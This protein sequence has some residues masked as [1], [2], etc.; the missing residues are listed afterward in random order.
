MNSTIIRKKKLCR[1]CGTDQYIFSK[2]RCQPC[3]TVEDTGKRVE[4]YAE[5]LIVKENLSELID[6]ADD[7]FSQYIRLKY[8]DDLGYCSCYT[9]GATKQW[10]LLQNG[11][12]MKRGHLYSRWD[13]RNCRPQDREC[14]EQKGGNLGEFTKRLEAERPGITDILKEESMIAYKPTRE[15][16]SQV[17]V[18]YRS[19][20][21]ELKRRLK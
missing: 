3:A 15:E 16:I 4:K 12:Y 8:T 17:I 20:V 10:T 7:V 9:C 19:K 2:G 14:N 13:E 5:S 6:K 1:S 18:E 11:H 21:N